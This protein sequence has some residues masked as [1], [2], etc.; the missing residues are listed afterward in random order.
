MRSAGALTAAILVRA[1][2]RARRLADGLAGR[3]AGHT[4]VVVVE[5]RPSSRAF[6][7]WTVLGLA[8]LVAGSLLV[9]SMISNRGG[10]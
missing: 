4:M 6:V 10:V 9:A 8:A 1:V 2:D 3:G 5:P 7:A